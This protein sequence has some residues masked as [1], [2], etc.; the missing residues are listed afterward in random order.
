MKQNKQS[1][2]VNIYCQEERIKMRN[3]EMESMA[4]VGKRIITTKYILIEA[5]IFIVKD[6]IMKARSC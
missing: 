2:R 6:R 3:S 4:H 5:K 1:R